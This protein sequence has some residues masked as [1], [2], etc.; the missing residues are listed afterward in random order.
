MRLPRC[1]GPP[2]LRE[3]QIAREF[4]IVCYQNAAMMPLGS[5]GAGIFG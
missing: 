3:G 1:E 4:A 2:N 5:A